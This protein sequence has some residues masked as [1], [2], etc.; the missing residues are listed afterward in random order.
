MN[1]KMNAKINAEKSA[2]KLKKWIGIITAIL[3]LSGCGASNDDGTDST[4]I[5]A[6]RTF[7]NQVLSIRLN[8][9]RYAGR[10]VR[11]EGIFHIIYSPQTGGEH[12]FVIRLAQGCCSVSH[13]GFQVFAEGI[14]PPENDAWVEVTGVLE[15]YNDTM[16]VRATSI[17]EMPERGVEFLGNER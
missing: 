16:V 10:V 8:P 9:R 4:I 1:A 6:E 13:I 14:V 11:Y 5:I 17:T 7:A 15:R 3:I 12:Y 2:I